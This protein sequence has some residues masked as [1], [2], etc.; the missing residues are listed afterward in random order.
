[1]INNKELDQRPNLLRIA[2]VVLAVAVPLIPKFPIFNVPG[3]YVAIRIEDF[4][5]AAF[6][7]LW[8]L[9]FWPKRKEFFTDILNIAIL[10]YLIVIGASFLSA[11]LITHSVVPHIAFLHWIRRIEY[12]LPFFIASLAM[13]SYREVYITL[14][15]LFAAGFIAVLYGVGQLYF[16]LPVIS[17]ANEE[18]SKGLLLPLTEGARVN[19]TFAGQFDLAAFLA[20]VLCLVTAFIFGFPFKRSTFL[21]EKAP[22]LLLAS[23]FYWLLLQTGSRVS[24]L[25]FIVGIGFVLWLLGKRRATVF[26]VGLCLLFGLF[27]PSELSE[28]FQITFKQNF[29]HLQ[30]KIS[31]KQSL[32]PNFPEVLATT[33]EDISTKS[34]SPSSRPITVPPTTAFTEEP[35]PGEPADLGE[36]IIFRSTNIRFNVEWPRATRAF[37]KNPLFGTGVS[38]ITLA[39]DN[40]YLRSLGETGLLGFSAFL[41]IFAEITRRII[42]FFKRKIDG[43]PKVFVV[44]MTGVLIA[45]A[46]NA[47][48]IDIFEASKIAILFWLL[49]GM[50][51]ATIRISVQKHG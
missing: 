35:A 26:V 25:A 24:F 14:R 17:T 42:T 33:V 34:S 12:F 9:Y 37:L 5:L 29:S 49:A 50:L 11:L 16:G 22:L 36:R 7:V 32:F 19:S 4:L 30:Q 31:D 23:S 3:T 41:V 48:L 39:T 15:F 21:K 51:I 10:F 20:I 28:R 8:F 46:I 43:E 18:F 27:F 6:G 47:L 38:S 40:D 45:L 44:G 2:V 1:M 13:T